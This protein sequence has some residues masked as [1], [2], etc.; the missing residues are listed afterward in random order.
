[1]IMRQV[2]LITMLAFIGLTSS[3]S[4][5]GYKYCL[6]GGHHGYPGLCHFSTYH[7]CQATAS[8]TISHCGVNP[9]FAVHG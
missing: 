1:M 6:Q 4:A 5:R 7:Q 8:G 3:A 2:I 9:H